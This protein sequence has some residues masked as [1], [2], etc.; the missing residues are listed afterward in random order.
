MRH[1]VPAKENFLQPELR[2]RGY[3]NHVI[4]RH[5]ASGNNGHLF[6]AIG[7]RIQSRLAFKFV[8]VDNLPKD[9]N[10]KD[11]YLNEAR[12]AN[13]I[14][15]PA[16]VR[17]HDVLAYFEKISATDCVVFVYDYV[18]GRNLRE[19][20]EKE[21]TR[22]NIN[23]SFI[24][25]FLRTALDLLFE[26]EK[27][28]LQHGDLH[29]GNILVSE[30]EYSRYH[31]LRFRITD[32]GVRNFLS[33]SGPGPIN[34][35]LNVGGILNSLLRCIDYESLDGRN[36]FVFNCLR[37][38]FLARHLF[39]SN[40]SID[41]LACN[42][43]KLLEKLD[44]LDDRFSVSDS[45]KSSRF[46]T[47]F[48]YPNCEQIGDSSSLL[49]GL[50]SD[51]LLGLN[52]I[53]SFSNFVLTGPR[54]CGKTTV[55]R[56]LSLNHL[57][58]ID[59]DNPSSMKYIG[60]Y[61]RCD[62]L[63]FAFPRYAE[64]NRPEALDLPMHFLTVTL[65]SRLLEQVRSWARKRHPEEYNRKEFA[66]V[67]RL[68]A[69]FE[70]NSERDKG[71]N[72]LV[73][74]IGRLK[75]RERQRAIKK[76]RFAA[77]RGSE[78]I[79]NYFG[80]EIISRACLV[81][82]NHFSFLRDLPFFFFIDDYS[83]PKITKT[84]QRNLNRVLMHRSPDVFFK[85]STESPVSFSRE[86]IDGKKFVESR[87]FKLLNLG[88]RYIVDS[89]SRTAEFLRDLFARR[90]SQVKAYPVQS[91]EQLLGL[92]SRNENATARFF[93]EPKKDGRSTKKKEEAY[94]YAGC[95]TV[96]SMC[97]GDIHYVIDLVSRM[98][99][100]FGG[101]TKLAKSRSTPKIPRH[102]QDRAVRQATGAFIESIRTLPYYGPRLADVV[103]AFGNVAHSYL[104]YADS[105][106]VSSKP[107]HQASRIEPYESLHLSSKAQNVLDELLRYSIFIED[108]RGRSRRGHTV[109]RF[110]LRRY[111]IPHFRLTFSRRDS[112]EL[113][114]S[115]I[116]MLLL[117]PQKFD[118]KMRLPD[119]YRRRPHD[120]AQEVLKL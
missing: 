49:K 24:E 14:A 87:E 86:D 41:K 4:Q 60:I 115:D 96:E 68:A 84:L 56:A 34:D 58:S 27:L 72:D 45:E 22:S 104:V 53:E 119:A 71:V 3:P 99:E 42:P 5:I 65:L 7:E 103:T 12:T 109:P 23:I 51:R 78:P 77:N 85:V 117:D 16:V 114:V 70:W 52:E 38:E 36:R 90:F 8:P 33:Q 69:L 11:S 82:R 98:V 120:P 67:T 15:N 2:I 111:L 6:L 106:N 57:T 9:P 44:S 93:R 73:G 74:V 89:G 75:T 40:Q 59:N 21:D 66:L 20:M 76:Q 46:V 29:A 25:E 110:Y 47:P 64:P 62:D 108:P 26:L 1:N 107:P 54:G 32:F 55:F 118:S 43:E 61:Y 92:A 48:D 102:I 105:S 100:T 88:L 63:Y 94:L 116:E 95:E 17:C 28:Q 97:S 35:F 101:R 13:L 30:N 18:E 80:P 37:D 113:E 10:D 50:Y 31:R 79:L 19:Y 81:I 91:L 112:L 39:E 83:H